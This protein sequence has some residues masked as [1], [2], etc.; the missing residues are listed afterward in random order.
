MVSRILGCI[1]LLFSFCAFASCNDEYPVGPEEIVLVPSG[2][3]FESEADLSV[4]VAYT[5][6]WTVELND[7]SWCR[8]DRRSSFGYDTITLSLKD[9][10]DRA[11]RSTVLTV[12][13]LMNPE[14]STS[15]TINKPGVDF[16]ASSEKILFEKHSKES[17]VTFTLS[18]AWT[19]ELSD[20][21]WCRV[22]RTSGTGDGEI[23]VSMTVPADSLH[24]TSILTI[25]SADYP[26]LPIEIPLAYVPPS[27]GKLT[28]LNRASRGKGIDIVI[29]GDGFTSTD[30]AAGGKWETILERSLS[31]LFRLEPFLT[32]RDYFNLYAVSA[33]SNSVQIG[34]KKPG[35]TFFGTYY[36]GDRYIRINNRPKVY[37]FAREYAPVK[38][39]ELAVALL[40]N[41]TRYGG[42][43]YF[44]QSNGIGVS[45]LNDFYF[46]YAL[47]HETLGH[48]FGKLAD[49]YIEYTNA[50][51][52]T[53]AAKNM[54]QKAM[55]G[56]Y[57]NVEYTDLPEAFTNA[58]WK[59]SLTTGYPGVG[60]FEGGHTY[61]SGVWRS[62]AESIMNGQT[63]GFNAVSREILVRRIY[64]QAG[65]EAEYS[66]DVFRQYDEINTASPTRQPDPIAL[67]PAW[68]P[69]I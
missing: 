42:T 35:D 24:K 63:G 30:F 27:H 23:T 62:S 10:T 68:Y 57:Q 17:T 36:S 50:I 58:F 3:A 46:E 34:S 6:A 21:S 55:Y 44:E 37:N 5:N 4:A 19:A 2:L 28:V 59:S 66:L 56:Y 26:S 65:L 69:P 13:S 9:K 40:V 38:S 31:A 22:D 7:D 16:R 61:P 8:I 15:I 20:N 25:A 45:P 60:V 52:E 53:T 67:P 33:V 51:P 18:G 29:L 32:F 11:K 54:L 48:A 49:E 14:L 47:I 41:D 1:I 43:A 39:E 64:R 12:A